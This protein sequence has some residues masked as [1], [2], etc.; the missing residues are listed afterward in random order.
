MLLSEA[1]QPDQNMYLFDQIKTQF[2]KIPFT[3]G[4]D[5]KG[6]RTVAMY[7]N[8]PI[9]NVKLGTDYQR[10]LEMRRLKWVNEMIH[11]RDAILREVVFIINMSNDVVDGSHRTHC[12]RELGIP[13][14]PVVMQCEFKT[15]E[16][17]AEYFIDINKINTQINKAHYIWRAMKKANRISGNLL[18]DMVDIN[19]NSSSMYNMVA[20]AERRGTKNRIS[21]GDFW[22]IV[23][24][25][26]FGRN[27]HWK[28]ERDAHCETLIKSFGYP[29]IESSVNQFMTWFKQCFG[30]KKT[31]HMAWKPKALHCFARVYMMLK[32]AKLL[33][34][35]R[36]MVSS[37]SKFKLMPINAETLKGDEYVLLSIIVNHWNK[38]K[39]VTA[40]TRLIMP[41]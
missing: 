3:D 17:E 15:F 40:R 24:K 37:I 1:K 21:I 12:F 28:M 7:L 29:T 13:F 38:N 10:S 18:Y 6:K 14:L 19:D 27:S 23:Y 2:V 4:F 31:G 25:V 30:E 36:Q 8:M 41:M 22:N 35:N 32:E 20:I 9:Q 33:E 5:E 16:D 34:T 26:G 39:L 11:E